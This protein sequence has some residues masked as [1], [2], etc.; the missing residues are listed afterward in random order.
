[1]KNKNVL[2]IAAHADDET[3]GCGGTIQKFKKLGHNVYV[4]VFTDGVSSRKKKLSKK[5]NDR[6]KQLKKVSKLLNFKIFKQ[7]NLPDNELDKIS[8][9]E[10]VK[11]IEAAIIKI[12]PE[13]ILTHSSKDLN[14]DHQKISNATIT[15]CRPLP[16]SKIK[17]LL[18]FEIPSSSEWNFNSNVINFNPNKFYDISGFIE[19]KLEAIKIYKSEIRQYPHP[20]SLE[21]IKTLSKFRGQCVGVNYAEAFEVGYIKD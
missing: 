3:L 6:S 15:A 9:L 18:F 7:Y 4:M 8:N 14:I 16:K 19:K 12:S 21:G 20:R 13:I 17:Q 11:K 5:I 2:V 1:M 10:L